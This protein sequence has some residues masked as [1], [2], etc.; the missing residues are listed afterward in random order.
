MLRCSRLSA[1]FS[2]LVR[3]SCSCFWLSASSLRF[4]SSCFDSRCFSPG[5]LA[6]AIFCSSFWIWLFCFWV[7]ASAC[8]S[9]AASRCWNALAA[10]SSALAAWAA[11]FWL[12]WPLSSFSASFCI[13]FLA[14]SRSPLARACPMLLVSALFSSSS[15][16][17]FRSLS[18]WATWSS[19]GPFMYRSWIF[20]SR[21]SISALLS[22]PRWAF[23][24]SFWISSAMRRSRSSWLAS[25]VLRSS[26][27]CSRAMSRSSCDSATGRLRSR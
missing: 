18:A 2:S 10:F 6:W 3:R 5:L 9:R 19:L 20:C 15:P 21:S 14:L 11:C 12:S 13:S 7:L 26:S 25:A 23:S 17:F 27:S 22:S 8:F 1:R 16:D 4:C 24:S